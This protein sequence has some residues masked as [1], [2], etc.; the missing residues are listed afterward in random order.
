MED[1]DAAPGIS[2]KAVSITWTD[3]ALGSAPCVTFSGLFAAAQGKIDKDDYIHV[4]YSI[5]AGEMW[6]PLVHFEGADL[7]SNGFNGN[8][9]LNGDFDGEGD[10]S[11]ATL[12]DTAAMYSAVSQPLN[13]ASALS[14]RL[15][16]Q[17]ESGDEYA[18]LDTFALTVGCGG[19]VSTTAAPTTTTTAAA[20]STTSAKLP[21]T[22]Q[23]T[24]TLKPSTSTTEAPTTTATTAATSTT[25]A[26]LPT[27]LQ[28]TPVPKSTR[29][30]S[31]SSTS[32]SSKSST[33]SASTASIAGS[34]FLSTLS[35]T[36]TTSKATTVLATTSPD[37]TIFF[38]PFE[39]RTLMSVAAPFSAVVGGSRAGYLGLTD[40]DA[41]DFGQDST[42][43]TLK[44]YQSTFLLASQVT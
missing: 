3:I 24:T 5:D 14:L 11:E 20:T 23:S 18:G 22:L 16:V 7:P 44:S 34:S 21:T 8:F 17:V 12:S 9:R 39:N 1:V 27:T 40:G 25:S 42:P 33:D 26:E 19:E 6:V 41:D 4:D 32:S 31:V 37:P 43:N 36:T 30:Q 38:E 13:G 35:S 10:A 15:S 29:I 28:S 2:S